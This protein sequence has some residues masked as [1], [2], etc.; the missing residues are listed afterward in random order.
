VA[1]EE[2]RT[3]SVTATGVTVVE[4]YLSDQWF[5]AVADLARPAIEAVRD[6]RNEFV[7][8]RW[9][10]SYFHWMEN[11]RDWTI[12]RQIWWG[13][14][15]PAWYC[16]DGHITVARDRSHRLRRPAARRPPPGRGRA[17]HLVLVR[18]VPVL[19]ARLARRD[20]RPRRFYPNAVL[21]TGFDIIYF[22]VARMMKMGIH[23]MGEVPFHQ[24]IIHGLVRDADGEKMSKSKGNTIDPL[25]VAEEY[26]ADP[27]RLALIQAANPGQDVPLDMEWV[28]GSP[29]VRQQAVERR[30]FRA[31]HVETGRSPPTAA[32]RRIPA[33]PTPG[34]WQR[35]GEVAREFDVLCD[36]YR[37]SDA[38]GC[39]TTSPGP[40]SST[41][42]WRC[43]VLAGDRT[44]GRHPADAGR[45]A[46]GPAQA[47]PPGHPVPHRGALAARGRRRAAG[48]G[49]LAA[50]P[51][52]SGPEVT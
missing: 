30:P 41:G 36:E 14:R 45:G 42:T 2:H 38:F 11:L 26:G 40:R 9:E 10:K 47:V 49:R 21:I 18:P 12:S 35:L 31:A 22:W 33:R 39:S 34:S 20:R 7:P 4:P 37:F 6:G 15:I 28:A 3:R 46:A 13:H 43:Q 1:V 27:L 25:D 52:V 17:R 32:I 8:K 24:T 5:V 16:P 48:R 29:P 50:G 23:F 51:V 44:A 19:D